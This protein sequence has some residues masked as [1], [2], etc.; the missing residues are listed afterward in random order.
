MERDAL[1]QANVYS[2]FFRVNGIFFDPNILGRYLA[3][4]ILAAPGAG[5]GAAPPAGAGGASRWPCR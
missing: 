4:A 1:Q 5:L 3:L 2:R